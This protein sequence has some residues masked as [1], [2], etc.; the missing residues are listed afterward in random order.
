MAW[1]P[2]W[3]WF[4]TTG[5]GAT[6]ISDLHSEL[7]V[8]KGHLAGSLSGFLQ[9][10]PLILMYLHWKSR[11]WFVGK[12]I[13]WISHIHSLIAARFSSV[14]CS[15]IRPE[16][17]CACWFFSMKLFL[18]SLAWIQ[19]ALRTS[20]AP[21]RGQMAATEEWVAMKIGF[22]ELLITHCFAVVVWQLIWTIP[23]CKF[24]VCVCV[25]AFFPSYLFWLPW[26]DKFLSFVLSFWRRWREH[27]G[28]ENATLN[29]I[30]AQKNSLYWPRNLLEG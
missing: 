28:V 5:I 2:L 10:F 23:L 9:V 7:T 21:K 6:A 1:W 16:H 30:I 22:T 15:I 20:D 25:C 3:G 4:L 14:K 11:S 8:G 19:D 18:L 24:A 27:F 29:W 13:E 26:R 12:I 17:P